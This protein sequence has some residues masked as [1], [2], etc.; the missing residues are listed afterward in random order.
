MSATIVSPT[1]RYHC[2]FVFSI[3]P[4]RFALSLAIYSIYMYVY[5]FIRVCVSLYYYIKLQ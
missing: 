4:M 2:K 3:N 1:Y 5:L